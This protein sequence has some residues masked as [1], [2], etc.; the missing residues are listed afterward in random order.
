MKTQETNKEMNALKEIKQ[1]RK[2]AKLWD[3]LVCE[4]MGLFPEDFANPELQTTDPKPVMDLMTML[5]QELKARRTGALFGSV[6]VK[7]ERIKKGRA[8]QHR[9]PSVCTLPRERIKEVDDGV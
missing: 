5:L 2:R 6:S 9:Q 4:A 3:D 7:I 1:W 8:I